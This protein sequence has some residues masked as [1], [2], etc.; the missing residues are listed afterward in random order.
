MNQPASSE[1]S[2]YFAAYVKLVPPGDIIDRMATEAD[3]H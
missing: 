3:H 1:Y 2:R